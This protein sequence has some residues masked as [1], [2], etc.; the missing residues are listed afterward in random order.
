MQAFK[1]LKIV[2]K[3]LN[4]E[5]YFIE[6]LEKIAEI[7]ENDALFEINKLREIPEKAPYESIVHY[8]KMIID[9]YKKAFLKN[10]MEAVKKEFTDG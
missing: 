2:T 8:Q 6:K 10:F 1:I 9:F 5:K 7:S 4:D 3:V